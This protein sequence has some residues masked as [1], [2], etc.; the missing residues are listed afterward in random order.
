[1]RLTHLFEAPLAD[2]AYASD[3]IPDATGRGTRNIQSDDHRILTS[4]KGMSKIYNA[5]EKTPFVFNIYVAPHA[6]TVPDIEKYLGRPVIKDGRITVIFTN[7]ATAPDGRMPMNAWTLA[8]RIAHGFQSFDQTVTNH[9]EHTIWGILVDLWNMTRTKGTQTAI[10]K[11][12][13]LDPVRPERELSRFSNSILTMKSARDGKIRNAL[14][15]GGEIVAQY[16]LTGRVKLARYSDWDFSKVPLVNLDGK[17]AISM[18]RTLSTID[19][20]LE[21]AEVRI[22]AACEAQFRDIVGTVVSF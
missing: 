19:R 3:V 11:G 15:V 10:F 8:H 12:D 2:L 14:D 21:D 20:F 17:P 1:M 6:I 22:N 9:I 18:T 16:L 5:F 7:N 13:F 4:P